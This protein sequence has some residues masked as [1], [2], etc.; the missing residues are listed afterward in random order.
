[1]KS[2][3]TKSLFTAQDELIRAARSGNG[4][5]FETLCT[6]FKSNINS[7]ILSLNVSP[8]ERDD[9]YQ[10]GLIGLLG[11]VRSYDYESSSFSTYASV[12]IKRSIISALRKINRNNRFELFANPESDFSSTVS[13]QLP[14]SGILEKES[15]R[16]WYDAFI[17]D[18]SPFEKRVFKMYIKGASYKK[19]ASELSCA[20]KSID[21]AITRIKSKLKRRLKQR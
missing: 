20:E 1:M 3:L 21:N 4:E 14:E 2:D 15:I 17:N 16:E 6:S 13:V 11:A 19:M 9:L 7:Y 12:C 8:S 10:E 5:A 18:L